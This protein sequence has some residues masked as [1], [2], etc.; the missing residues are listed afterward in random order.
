MTR[1]DYFSGVKSKK[2]AIEQPF[3]CVAIYPL[4]FYRFNHIQT[5][6]LCILSRKPLYYHE[7]SHPVSVI[8]QAVSVFVY[9][10]CL[11]VSTFA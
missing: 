8:L 4:S 9:G 2:G 3:S 11:R 6:K 7:N 5:R 1:N 10:F